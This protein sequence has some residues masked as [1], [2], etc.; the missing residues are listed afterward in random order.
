MILERRTFKKVTG[1][2]EVLFFSRQGLEYTITPQ[3]ADSRKMFA[4]RIFQFSSNA[5]KLLTGASVDLYTF[6]VPVTFPTHLRIF[7]DRS[8][9]VALLKRKVILP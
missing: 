5:Q 3:S 2:Y 7:E 8:R 1:S 4:R 9:P 6:R